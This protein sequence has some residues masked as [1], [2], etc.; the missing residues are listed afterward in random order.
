MIYI[1][2]AGDALKVGLTNAPERRLSQ[3]QIS[4]HARV[5]LL[6]LFEGGREEEMALHQKYAADRIGGE[7]FRPVPEL[8]SGDVGLPALPIPEMKLRRGPS[9]ETPRYQKWRARRPG[10]SMGAHLARLYWTRE[11]LR[12]VGVSKERARGGHL[13]QA[14]ALREM[15]ERSRL[16]LIAIHRAPQPVA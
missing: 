9:I 15:A 12:F 2:Q 6:H 1:M 8:L 11:W 5:I 16:Q 3:I 13:G 4:H 7:W 10:E 14:S